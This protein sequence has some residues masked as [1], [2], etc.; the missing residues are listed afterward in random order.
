MKGLE[1][2]EKGLS[3]W[4]TERGKDKPTDWPWCPWAYVLALRQ[5]CG[6]LE[7]RLL[8]LL[9]LK[10]FFGLLQIVTDAT[11]CEKHAEKIEC[12]TGNCRFGENSRVVWISGRRLST[13]GMGQILCYCQRNP[14]SGEK[15]E[16]LAL[17]SQPRGARGIAQA[18]S[19]LSEDLS[20]APLIWG[21]HSFL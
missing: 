6:H 17:G 10:G 15:P 7:G 8:F 18:L 9:L 13:M 4:K 20:C 12:Q 14:S 19:G 11:V 16:L 1:W 3:C 2:W 21:S 5:A